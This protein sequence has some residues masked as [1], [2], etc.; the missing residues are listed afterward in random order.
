ME[1]FN[2]DTW[3]KDK[4]RKICT[5]DGKPVR[6]ICWDLKCNT[7]IIAAIQWNQEREDSYCYDTAGR[8]ANNVGEIDLFFAD[9]EEELSEFEEQLASILFD[10]EYEGKT[11]TEDDIERGMLPYRLAAKE[12]SSELLGLARKEIRKEQQD[13]LGTLEMPIDVTEPYYIKG[14]EDALKDLPKWRKATK[15]K[16]FDKHVCVM[17]YYAFPFLDTEVNEGDYYIKLEDLKTLPKEE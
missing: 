4:S 1:Q 11:N 17:D 13:K 16:E 3:L 15:C 5:R 6:I 12:Y 9:E 2:L 8:C 14:R 10:R 7:P